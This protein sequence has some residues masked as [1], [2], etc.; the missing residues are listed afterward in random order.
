M[1]KTKARSNPFY[2][3]LL[4]AGVAFVLT[5]CA[6]GV[7]AFKGSRGVPLGETGMLAFLD[8]HGVWL[9]GGEVG[10]L[11]LA[12]LAAMLTDGYWT[13][14]SAGEASAHSDSEGNTEPDT[15][16]AEQPGGPQGNS[17]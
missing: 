15:A 11:I 3:L 16:N 1:P 4:V 7:M 6:Y 8:R 2:V 10:V 5:A 9:L 17:P 14:R 13:G 12:S